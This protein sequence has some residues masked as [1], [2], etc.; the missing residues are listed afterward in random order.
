MS[1]WNDSG[2]SEKKVEGFRGFVGCSVSVRFYGRFVCFAVCSVDYYVRMSV[3]LVLSYVLT[4]DS[5][6]NISF[7]L[8][9]DYSTRASKKYRMRE[10]IL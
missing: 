10:L 4:F 9:S 1:L 8:C 7:I 2:A 6:T 3:C 5:R